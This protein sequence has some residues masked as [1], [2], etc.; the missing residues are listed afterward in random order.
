ML[1]MMVAGCVHTVTRYYVPTE[2]A[3]R[4]GL[5]QLRSQAD[6]ILHLECPRLLRGRAAMY[7]EA[8][9]AL[10]LDA[11]GDVQRVHLVRGSSSARLDDVLGALAAQLHLAP[12]APPAPP[13]GGP[14]SMAMA[15]GY[16]CAATATAM[17][18]R[19]A[20]AR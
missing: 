9:L 16:S 10:D 20:R 8:D 13:G 6:A 1:A 4:I 18:I 3:A 15:A 11:R 17:T 2:G 19:L 7:G 12:P 5:D 14:A